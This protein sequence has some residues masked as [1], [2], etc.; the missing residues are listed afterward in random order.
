M[1]NTLSHQQ[2]SF[3]LIFELVPICFWMSKYL[4]NKPQNGPI[5][6]Y[7][8]YNNYAPLLEVQAPTPGGLA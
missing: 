1:S 2:L 4:K 5:L 8:L 3:S 6:E 7:V